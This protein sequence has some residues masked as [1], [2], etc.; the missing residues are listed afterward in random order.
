MKVF[1]GH[2]R[3][4]TIFDDGAAGARARAERGESRGKPPPRGGRVMRRG[5]FQP[6]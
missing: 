5:T 6:P 3:L 1:F 2:M 4:L